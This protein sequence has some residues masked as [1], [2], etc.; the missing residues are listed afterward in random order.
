ME[1]YK[2]CDKR[3]F[4]HSLLPHALSNELNSMIDAGFITKELKAYRLKVYL[5]AQK[6]TEK[7]FGHANNAGKETFGFF[8]LTVLEFMESSV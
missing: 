2:V 7:A 4:R 6:K 5:R 8:I 1:V 3:L